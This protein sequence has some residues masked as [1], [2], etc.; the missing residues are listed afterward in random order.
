V[1]ALRLTLGCYWGDN[2]SQS[3]TLFAYYF[4]V[5]AVVPR[6]IL[7]GL[8][9]LHIIRVWAL[10]SLEL[11]HSGLQCLGIIRVRVLLSL[12]SLFRAFSALVLFECGRSCPSNLSF[13]P[14][15][16]WYYSSAGT[17][18]PRIVVPHLFNSIVI[19]LFDTYVV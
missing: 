14:S 11:L 9:H 3:T 12:E 15:A 10:L 4:R 19:A 2:I 6:N 16:P 7:L 18:V 17:L 1:Q 13:G 5:R 8:Q